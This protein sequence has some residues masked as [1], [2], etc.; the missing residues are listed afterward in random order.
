MLAEFAAVLMVLLSMRR[1]DANAPMFPGS[2]SL[3]FGVAYRWII[4]LA[5]LLA[6]GYATKVTADYSRRLVLT[7]A[8]VVVPLLAAV[9][10]ALDKMMWRLTCDPSNA[11]KTVFVGINDISQTLAKQLTGSQELCMSV[12]GFFDDRSADRLELADMK[13]HVLGR[14]Q[15][16]GTYVKEHGVQV[17]FISLP[18]RHLQRVRDLLDELRD[19]TASIYYLPDIFAFDLIQSRSGEIAG[20][21]FVALCE[22]PFYGFRGVVKRLMDFGISG[23]A[24]LLASPIMMLIALLVRFSSVG[25]VIFRQR[26]YGLDGREFIVYKFRTM[27][28]TEDGSQIAQARRDDQRFTS[29]GRFLRRYSLDELPQL[30]NVLQGRMS[31]VGPRPHAV[32]HNEEYRKLIKGYMI[33]HKVLPGITGLA[34]IN[35]C[36]GETAQLE[37][38]RVRL[39]YD[40]DYL[41]H[42]SPLLDLKILGRTAL[43][44]LRNDKAY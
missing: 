31:L 30:I 18:M 5:I 2:A 11:R 14:L 35:G 33:R 38:M 10:V 22:T 1:R 36:R 42:W 21:P 23:A 15:E 25:S 9:A 8:V 39:Q 32:A 16:L 20:I 13:P 26:R 29:I 37:D 44:L 3:M 19:T 4:V 6:V 7:W 28:V 40:L 12:Q 17:I 27:T 43:Q 34:Q 41:R 24:L